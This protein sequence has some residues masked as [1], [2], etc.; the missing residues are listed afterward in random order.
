[1]S[2]YLSPEIFLQTARMLSGSL[3]SD[4]AVLVVEGDSD[5]RVFRRLCRS[6]SQ[7]LPTN[8]EEA[9]PGSS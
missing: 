5:S 7:V 9:A 4:L 6:Q 3:G 8:G 1:M 2:R